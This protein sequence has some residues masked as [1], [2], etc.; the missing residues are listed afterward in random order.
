MEEII[1]ILLLTFGCW[2]LTKGMTMYDGAFLTMKKIRDWADDKPWS[3]LFC[4]FCTSI[5]VAIALTLLAKGLQIEVI[6]WSLGV[7]G[8]ANLVDMI[9]EKLN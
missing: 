4:F 2:Y 3:P 1:L 7:A 8:L 5:W 6:Y 9:Y